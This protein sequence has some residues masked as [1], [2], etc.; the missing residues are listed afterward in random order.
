MRRGLESIVGALGGDLYAGGRRAMVPGPGHSARDRS[1]S[2]L[3]TGG[4]RVI[5][6]SFA[7]DDWRSVLDELRARGLVDAGNRVVGSDTRAPPPRPHAPER[8]AVA[9]GLWAESRELTGTPGERHVRRRGVRRD[10]PSALRFHPAVPSA[11]YAGRGVRRGALIA[12]IHDAGGRLAGVEVTYL[13]PSGELARIPVVR[14]TIG[15]R[16]AGSAVR[17][18]PAGRSLVVGEGVFSCL[19]ASE[20]LEAPAW[21]LLAL[22]NLR[23]WTPP[24]G[25]RRV[26]IAAD[27]GPPGEAAAAVLLRRLKD[28]GLRAEVRLP[29]RGYPD[30][31][32]ARRAGA[33]EEAVKGGPEGGMG[34]PE[35]SG[36]D[37]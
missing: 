17:L 9:A 1:V 13:D 3:L 22:G 27:R 12:A 32:D 21:A 18:D 2:L 37:P 23:A 34:P 19:S 31:N 10:L 4:G 28:M 8:L 26:L 11:V 20:A 16:P 35:G 5:A 24:P 7:G 6:H 14:K 25:V 15:A 36:D 33:G 29:P 30:W